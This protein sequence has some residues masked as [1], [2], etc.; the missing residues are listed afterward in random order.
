MEE[1]LRQLLNPWVLGIGFVVIHAYVR[2]NTPPT[3]RSL[4][5]AGRYYAAATAYVLATVL[6]YLV[7]AMSPEL[8]DYFSGSAGSAI[9]Q[10]ARDL[11]A[12]FFVAL[13]LT[14]LL[15]KVPYLSDMDKW[16]VGFL[17]DV[18]SIPYEARRLSSVLR[19]A[20]FQV[21]PEV[22][23]AVAEELKDADFAP[24][25]ILFEESHAPQ[26]LWTK[27]SVLMHHLRNWES[28]RRWAG[29]L[30]RYAEEFAELKTQYEQLTIKARRLFGLLRPVAGETHDL[31]MVGALS[32]LRESFEEQ[33]AE[34]HKNLCYF[35]SRGVLKCRMRENARRMEIRSMGFHVG[36]EEREGRLFDRLMTLFLMLSTYFVVMMAG[37]G[38]PHLTLNRRMVA[39]VMISSVYCIAVICALYSKRWAS[40][41]P[42]D[43]G[44]PVRVYFVAGVVA[45]GIA[46]VVNLGLELS[47]RF[48]FGQSWDR[49]LVEALR[50]IGKSYPWAL[51]VLITAFVTA[52]HADN[53]NRPSLRWI[54]GLSQA[55][56]TAV[57]SAGVYWVLSQNGVAGGLNLYRLALGALVAGFVIG[58][59]V[60]T[61]YRDYRGRSRPE[62][63]AARAFALRPI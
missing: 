22:Q 17:Q 15:P 62:E 53:Q 51:M 21:T 25:D 6:L 11:S 39:G 42:T 13:L 20:V 61:W 33:L 37:F 19:K 28:E 56:I 5:T 12:P 44:R 31:K 29:F 23:E 9:S 24:E 47:W 52:F 58:F 3:S 36:S 54:E 26:Y 16:L 49:N 18:A 10:E 55:A 38:S 8:L 27:I 32:E 1:I 63:E 46:L 59:F 45:A 57:G 41:G 35:I 14:V 4:T 34:L 48:G 50:S 7:L 30:S 2:F 43:N 40:A 60:P